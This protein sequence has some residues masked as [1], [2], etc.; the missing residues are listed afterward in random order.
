MRKIAS[1]LL[2]TA[3]LAAPATAYSGRWLVVMDRDTGTCYRL[4]QMPD[5]KNWVQLGIFNTF[6]AAGQWTWEHRGEICR[7]SPVFGTN[8]SAD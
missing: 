1:A 4:T 5:G 8:L 2:I 3:A 7:S 6:R